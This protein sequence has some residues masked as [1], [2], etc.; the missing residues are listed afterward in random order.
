MIIDRHLTI[1]EY[2]RPG[3]ALDMVLA[4]VMHWTANPK[5]GA[6]GNRNYFESRKDGKNGYGSAHYIIG[7][8]GNVIRCIP[9]PERAYHCGSSQID[10]SSGKIYTDLARKMFGRYASAKSSPNC[11]TIG[12]ELCPTDL[13]GNFT[14][15]TLAEAVDLVRVLCKRYKLAKDAIITHNQVVG[16]KDCPRLWVK[17]PELFDKFKSEV[18]A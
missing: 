17:H 5:L 6:E 3:T 8:T 11:V 14:R 7:Q 4:V 13:D 16:W 18:F 9:E 10:P 15:E 2:S 12:I 1:N